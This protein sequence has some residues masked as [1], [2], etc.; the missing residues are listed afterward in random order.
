MEVF[1]KNGV[2]S[3]SFLKGGYLRAG[4]NVSGSACN[5]WKFINDGL[6]V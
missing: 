2:S 5:V 6:G 3:P 4:A 1:L